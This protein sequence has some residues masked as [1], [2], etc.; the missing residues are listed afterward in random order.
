[1]IN[2]VKLIQECTSSLGTR[3]SIEFN[4]ATECSQ[5]IRITFKWCVGTQYHD[6][7]RIYTHQMMEDVICGVTQIIIDDFIRHT[8]GDAK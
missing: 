5:M 4:D 2:I 1:M 6:L 7:S 8:S 3:V